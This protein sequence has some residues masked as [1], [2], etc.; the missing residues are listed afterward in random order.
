[1]ID[2][3]IKLDEDTHRRISV[4]KY[5]KGLKNHNEAVKWLLDDYSK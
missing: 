3:Q 1:M 2:K 5:D 4:L